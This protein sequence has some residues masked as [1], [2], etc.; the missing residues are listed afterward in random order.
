MHFVFVLL[1]VEGWGEYTDQ[2]M[3]K[4]VWGIPLCCNE[5]TSGRREREAGSCLAKKQEMWAVH[6]LMDDRKVLFQIIIRSRRISCC[7]VNTVYCR[8]K[9]INGKGAGLGRT[10]EETE[11]SKGT[12]NWVLATDSVR[13]S[14]TSSTLAV[15]LWGLLAFP[16]TV[17]SS[18]C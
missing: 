14:V 5:A 11:T 8:I 1:K 7:P 15:I 3:K 10:K 17:S 4:S 16:D 6:Q 9:S 2:I 12:L 13:V 18:C